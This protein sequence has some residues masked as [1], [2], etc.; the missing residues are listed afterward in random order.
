MVSLNPTLV[1]LQSLHT[2]ALVERAERTSVC[3]VWSLGS[4]RL[5]ELR[6]ITP[7]MPVGCTL[8]LSSLHFFLVLF[9]FPF[10][11]SPAF[12]LKHSLHQYFCWISWSLTFSLLPFLSRT[13]VCLYPCL[14]PSEVPLGRDNFAGLPKG[15]QRRGNVLQH[16]LV[17]CG[18]EQDVSKD[19]A[20][21]E[22]EGE[23]EETER[24]CKWK[25]E[26]I[27]K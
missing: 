13:S 22:K 12:S 24:E 14:A 19:H 15:A 26:N 10:G 5:L 1:P 17:R 25:V 9:N 3:V 18:A 21:G 16:M 11:F 27:L 2:A 23:V 8:F 20:E 4:L 7:T 6:R